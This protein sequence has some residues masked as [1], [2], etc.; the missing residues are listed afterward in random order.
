MALD[1]EVNVLV[2]DFAQVLLRFRFFAARQQERRAV[3]Q[4]GNDGDHTQH[5]CRNA[6]DHEG[7]G[8]FILGK[9]VW[10]QGGGDE[11]ASRRTNRNRGYTH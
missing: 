4:E 11:A 8:P 2:A 10:R 6:K 3:T 5:Q 7:A 1:D 9:D